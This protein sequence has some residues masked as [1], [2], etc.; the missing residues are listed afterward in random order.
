LAIGVKRGN[1]R[2]DLVQMTLR[3]LSGRPYAEEVADVV[4]WLHSLDG[5]P[6]IDD[7]ITATCRAGHHGDEPGT[8]FYVE[9][10]PAEGVARLR[11]LGC[12]G[13]HPVLDS[14][15]RWTFP[16]AWSCPNCRQAIAEVVFGLHEEASTVTWAAMAVRCVNCG[17][18]DGVADFVVPGLFANQFVP[19]AAS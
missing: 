15:E 8:W 13:V 1:A 18:L 16:S 6:A 10:D 17:S 19:G 2:A 9:A 11:C 14:A 12:G 5:C 4:A 3:S 7:A